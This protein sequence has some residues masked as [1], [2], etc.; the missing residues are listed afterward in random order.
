MHH[1]FYLLHY[2]YM[3]RERRCTYG[4]LCYFWAGREILQIPPTIA[5]KAVSDFY[6]LKTPPVSAVAPGARYTISGLNG[7]RGPGRPTR[8]LRGNCLCVVVLTLCISAKLYKMWV[9][10]LSKWCLRRTYS[11]L[12]VK[13]LQKGRTSYR[14]ASMTRYSINETKGLCKDRSSWRSV[15]FVN[16]HKKKA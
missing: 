8:H 6:W 2:N 4:I 9:V 5:R 10:T 16:L 11:D 12:S 7:S 15:L 1:T 3:W 14:H 13:V